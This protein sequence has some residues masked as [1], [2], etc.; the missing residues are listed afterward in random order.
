MLIPAGPMT[1]ALVIVMTA[2]GAVVVGVPGETPRQPYN[3]RRWGGV[4][5]SRR[6][7]VVFASRASDRA[8]A[9]CAAPL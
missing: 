8:V 6:P 1:Q 4:P 2:A 9:V 7:F 5:K 3:H